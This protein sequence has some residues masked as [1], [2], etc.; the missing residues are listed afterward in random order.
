LYNL[1]Q[2]PQEENNLM[3]SEEE[4]YRELNKLMMQHIQQGGQVPWQRK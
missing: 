3:D 2:D 1:L 4:K